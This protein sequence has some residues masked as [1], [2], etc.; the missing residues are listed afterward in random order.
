MTRKTKKFAQRD[1]SP[2]I[3]SLNFFAPAVTQRLAS[4]LIRSS[5]MGGGAAL[6]WNTLV[7]RSFQIVQHTSMVIKAIALRLGTLLDDIMVH[8]DLTDANA[9]QSWKEKWLSPSHALTR[10]QSLR[11][12]RHRLKRCA[13]DSCICLHRGQRRQLF[14]HLLFFL[15]NRLGQIFCIR[16]KKKMVKCLLYARGLSVGRHSWLLEFLNFARIPLIR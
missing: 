15:I 7:F 5:S 6:L 8:Q 14:Q 11:V 13:A 10:L 9:F 16:F 12:Y 3:T 1:Y 4:L 2:N